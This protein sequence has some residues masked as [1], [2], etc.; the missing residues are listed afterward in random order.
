MALWTP[1][2]FTPFLAIELIPFQ[3]CNARVQLTCN[4]REGTA[5]NGRAAQAGVTAHNGCAATQNL[6]G[7][8]YPSRQLP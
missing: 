7:S 4:L 5:R 1:R 3:S 8:P 2:G 6:Q